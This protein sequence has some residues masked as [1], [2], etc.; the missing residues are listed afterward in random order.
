MI[1]EVDADHLLAQLPVVMGLDVVLVGVNQQQ[2]FVGVDGDVG[3]GVLRI[4]LDGSIPFR[5]K[6]L[7]MVWIGEDLHELEV[8]FVAGERGS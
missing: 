4:E 8:S 6:E 5:H 3:S 7:E 1:G 2:L